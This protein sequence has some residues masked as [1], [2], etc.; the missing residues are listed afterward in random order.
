MNCWEMKKCGRD[1]SKDCPAVPNNGN[2]C[3]RVA[4]TMCGDDVQGT[5]AQKIKDC[6]KCE[7]Y[8]INKILR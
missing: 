6:M 8:K 2:I 3:W 5:Y 1:L 7:V 4:G